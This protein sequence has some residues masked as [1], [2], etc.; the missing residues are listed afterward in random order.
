MLPQ[1]SWLGAVLQRSLCRVVAPSLEMTTMAGAMAYSEMRVKRH[2]Q[3]DVRGRAQLSPA[4]AGW[5]QGV[6]S[7]AP[8]FGSDPSLGQGGG[9]S[10]SEPLGD[11]PTRQERARHGEAL[12]TLFVCRSAHVAFPPPPP[13]PIAA[14]AQQPMSPACLLLR[15]I[16]ERLL[17]CFCRRARAPDR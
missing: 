13:H 9:R 10:L 7:P 4:A 14:C 11:V 6:T 15:L 12:Q 8:A 2:G 1:R 3:E 16:V 17:C 5:C